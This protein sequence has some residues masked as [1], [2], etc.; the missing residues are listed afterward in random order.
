MVF[1]VNALDI[2]SDNS[3]RKELVSVELKIHLSTLVSDLIQLLMN[4]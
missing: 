1:V 3:F 4:Y 2:F